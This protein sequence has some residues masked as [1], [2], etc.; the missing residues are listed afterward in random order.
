MNKPEQ[1]FH[2]K[3]MKWLRYNKQLFPSSY[4]IE[5]KVVRPGSTRFPLRELSDKER[6]LLGACKHDQVL[7]THSDAAG[8][9]TLC[10]GSVISGGGF[11]FLHWVRRF[12]KDFYV[13]DIDDLELYEKKHS[14]KS[15][16]DEQAEHISLFTG[17]LK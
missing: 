13:I 15:L 4:M 1:A 5:T 17:T 14:L 8:F 16:T 12:N 7:H 3:L 10:D 11:I 9:G 6:R 2:S